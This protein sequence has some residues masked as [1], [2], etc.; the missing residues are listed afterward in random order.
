MRRTLAGACIALLLAGCATPR[1]SRQPLSVADQQALLMALPGFELEGRTGGRAGDEGFNG[2]LSWRQ[3]AADA[4]IHVSGPLGAGG[5]TLAFTPQSLRVTSSRGDEYAGDEA[6]AVIAT[7][8]GFVPPFES[9]R[10]WVLGLAAPGEPVTE[11][12][13][14]ADGQFTRFVQQGWL[15]SYDRRIGVPTQVGEV[16]LPKKLSATRADLRLQVVVESW[17]LRVAD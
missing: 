10:Y 6:R 14:A 11:V 3:Q 9:L 15:V 2:Q 17:K 8:L 7:Q 1:L 16:K 12:E 13:L 5:L 4:R